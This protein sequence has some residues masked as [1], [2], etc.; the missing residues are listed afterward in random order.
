[1]SAPVASG[2][3]RAG[4]MAALC[5]IVGCAAL[6]RTAPEPVVAPAQAIPPVP[7]ASQTE[8]YQPPPETSATRKGNTTD[9]LIIGDSQISFGAGA[10]HLAL[11]G[12]LASACGADA[13]QRAQLDHLA[14][15]RAAAIGVRSTSLVDWTTADR[16]E[17]GL[18]CDK[19]SAFGVN[20]GVYGIGG[21]PDLAFVQIG[22]GVDY[23]FCTPGQS[24]MQAMLSEPAY[25]PDLLVLAFLGNAVDRW[26][27][28][29]GA[30][31]DDLRAALEQ[32][33]QGMDCIVMTTAPAFDASVNDRRVVAQDNLRQALESTGRQCSFVA[34][35]RPDTVAATQDNPNFFRR[36]DAGEVID[37][38]HL[39]SDGYAD[40][41]TRVKPALCT[42]VFEQVSQ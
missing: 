26:A 7:A 24:V 31:R 21:D 36:N 40:F 1:M 12:N 34:G 28:P 23:P 30:V 6:V 11:F 35:I 29:H 9:V 32:I 37:R 19:D 42:A 20:A 2:L 38:F 13:R 16:D 10:G 39:N 22:E 8:I 17:Q 3:R 4:I 14:N 41:F 25:Q 33:P 5:F 18:I 27:T 15:A